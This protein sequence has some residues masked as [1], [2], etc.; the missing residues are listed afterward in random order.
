L[1]NG[2]VLDLFKTGG[3]DLAALASGASF[4]QMFRTKKTPDLVG[5][6]GRR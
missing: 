4:Q 2:G 5:A 6:E 1:F 3:R